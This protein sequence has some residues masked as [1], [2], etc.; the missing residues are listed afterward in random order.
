MSPL[1][2]LRAMVRRRKPATGGIVR[3]DPDR[4]LWLDGGYGGYVVP[5]RAAQAQYEGV[6]VRMR[7]YTEMTDEEKQQFLDN[8]NALMK[9]PKCGQA[10]C[11]QEPT[12]P[13]G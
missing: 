7:G 1:G 5:T 9:R 10:D 6:T 2:Y 11:G 3:Y 12:P 13:N 4:P 8:V